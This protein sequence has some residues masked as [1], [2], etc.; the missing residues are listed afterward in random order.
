MEMTNFF[1]KSSWNKLY[2]CEKLKHIREEEEMVGG[3]RG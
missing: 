3:R 1:D 2:E